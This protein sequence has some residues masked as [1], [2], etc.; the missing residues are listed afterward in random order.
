MTCMTDVSVKYRN[1]SHTGVNLAYIM[2]Q[3]FGLLSIDVLDHIMSH[4]VLHFLFLV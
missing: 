3:Y 1:Y 2:F 4:L